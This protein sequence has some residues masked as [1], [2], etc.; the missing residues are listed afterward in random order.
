MSEQ[1]LKIKAKK[2][3]LIICYLIVGYAIYGTIQNFEYVK[4]SPGLY[5]LI[6]LFVILFINMHRAQV[7]FDQSGVKRAIFF[8]KIGIPYDQIEK[9]KVSK[10]RIKIY[11]SDDAI[12]FNNFIFTNFHLAIA[13][14]ND[15]IDREIELT[16]TDEYVQEYFESVM[17]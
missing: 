2:W 3:Y 6:F 7:I 9:I 17:N 1:F 15:N 13:L 16:G 4:D 12:S 8:F 11:S 14:L 5:F 10:N